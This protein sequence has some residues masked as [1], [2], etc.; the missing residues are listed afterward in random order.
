MKNSCLKALCVCVCVWLRVLECV[1]V[2]ESASKI[3]NAHTSDYVLHNELYRFY[4]T[5]TPNAQAGAA[6][7]S[8][9]CWS[10]CVL[11]AV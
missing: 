11:K 7:H 3:Q 4:G 9:R 6:A 8:A 2:C 1:Y 10:M 5:A